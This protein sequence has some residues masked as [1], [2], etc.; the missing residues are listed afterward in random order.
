MYKLVDRSLYGARAPF[1]KIFGKEEKLD[2]MSEE[3]LAQKMG[4]SGMM[5]MDNETDCNCFAYET[6]ETCEGSIMGCIW[7]PLFESC[8]PPEMLDEGSPICPET[9]SPTISPTQ[10][11]YLLETESPTLAP[12]HAPVVNSTGDPWYSSYFR[13]REH[14]E[15]GVRLLGLD[16]IEDDDE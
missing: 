5:G 14:E 15:D 16:E 13:I 2:G 6:F 9:S 8:H 4:D 7:R 3:E 10:S 1:I 12:S 11:G